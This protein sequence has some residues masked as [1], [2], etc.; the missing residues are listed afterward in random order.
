MRILHLTAGTGSFYCGTC[1][2]DNALAG[3]L[4][5]AGHE[6]VLQP[7]YLPIVAEGVSESAG[8]PIY[9]GG[10]NV[11]LQQELALFRALPTWADRWLDSAPVL[12]LAAKGAGMTRPEDT[13]PLTVSMLEGRGGLQGKEIDRLLAH[14][15]AT[16]R[17]DVV[18]L[19]NSLLVGLAA[20]LRDGLD[21]PVVCT[22]QGEAHFV[23]ALPEPW[24][25]RAWTALAAGLRDCAGWIAVSGFARDLMAARAGLDPSQVAV[26]H[27]GVALAGRERARHDGP[28]VLGFLARMCAA[29]GMDRLARAWLR[30]RQRPGLEDLRLVLAGT[31]AA[32]D[33]AYVAQVRA[34][35][36]GMDGV[37][38]LPNVA[39]Q[40]KWQAL[41]T[42][43]VL[44]VPARR[45]KTFGLYVLE[46]LA[47]GVP[48]V[49][50]R[51]GALA[52]LL[53]ATGGGVLVAPDDD[54]A[55]DEALA[56][57]L[58]DPARRRAL[59]AAGAA[60]VG[61]RFGVDAMAEETGRVLEE[62]LRRARDGV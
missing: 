12:G 51:R 40:D 45:D 9:F 31:E 59:G 27:N 55:L 13:G 14:L 19:S 15:R 61:E 37:S 34:N 52:E 33:R 2:R 29:N 10:V 56:G 46:A 6:V 53:E 22:L 5:A 3:G 54:D 49:S 43:S 41:T 24:R 21:V 26:V 30:L 58:L 44:C 60:S 50:P 32:I 23:D 42:W 17:P 1:I 39:A 35:L 16:P 18:V 7:L 4:R 28:P 57:L 11:Y 48:V 62:V 25:Q 47:C 38:W 8:T 36:E 20:P